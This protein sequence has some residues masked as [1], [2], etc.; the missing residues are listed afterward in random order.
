MLNKNPFFIIM[1]LLPAFTAS[2]GQQFF[3]HGSVSE[4]STGTPL[5]YA[6]IRV[7]NSS[8]GTSSNKNGRY[9]LKLSKGKYKIFAS[10]IGYSSDTLEIN[11]QN[12]LSD[13][14]FKLRQTNITLPEIVV[15]PGENPALR[16][17]KAAIARKEEKD[18]ILNSYEFDAYTKAIIKT[19]K[20]IGSNGRGI[21]MNIGSDTSALK[22][23]GIIENESKG[24][25][26]KPNLYKEEITARRQ[27][28]N[29]P[30]S[31]NILT[32]GRIMKDFSGDYVNLLGRDIPGPL[33][34]N[35]LDYYFFHIDMMTSINNKPVYVIYMT[36]N[37]TNDPGFYGDIY[38]EDSTY[39]LIKVD[40]HINRAANI[41]GILDSVNIYQQFAAYSNSI[42]MPVDYRLFVKA[43]VLGLAKF[44]LELNTILYDYKIKTP[45]SK[46][47]FNKAVIT[48]LPGADKKDSTYWNEA[49][50]VPSTP[51]EKKAYKRIDSLSSIKPTFWER[52]SL[53]ST[54]INLT[55]NFSV[56][57]PL[58]MYHFNRVE[59]NSLD[60]GFF[61]SDAA[62]HRLNSSLQFDYGFS[63][64][65]FKT[66]F[67]ISY[68]L[69]DYRTY[70]LSFNA[71]NRLDVLF[72]ESENYNDFFSSLLALISKDDFR[73]YY[74]SKGFK[75]EAAGDVSPVIRLRAG[76]MNTT[77]KSA[78]RNTEFSF[79]AKDKQ[80]NPNPAI[81]D[82][83]INAVNAGFK[84]D[85]RDYIENGISR[86]RISENKSYITFNGNVT[87][88]DKSLL[89]SSLYY[90]TYELSSQGVLNTFT[91]Q[92]LDFKIFGMYTDGKLPYQNLYSLPG[93]IDL[94]AG[95][96]TF[97]TLN[98]NEVLGDRVVEV[99]LEH[100]FGDE[101]F[102][103][104]RIPYLQDAELQLT[105]FI[106]AAYS[107]I[108]KGSKSILPEEQPGTTY[109]IKTLRHPFYEAGFELGHVLFPFKL[110]FAWRLNY[111]GE[112]NFRIGLN[113]FFLW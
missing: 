29:F 103:A 31:I 56:S 55:D 74:Y 64:K 52:F 80:Y 7:L 47:F 89:K 71:F 14:N 20:A 100:E 6:N 18:K 30:P 70:K 87:L 10:Y 13:V 40:L 106:N 91:S 33:A 60:Y 63:D 79:F 42:Y 75:F 102:R 66:D 21:S 68:L 22:I 37:N 97:R 107:D 61:L 84:L 39:E 86:M 90:T 46:S 113:V 109:Q 105:G 2:F 88:S 16:I 57:A 98:V 34:P 94:T 112:N 3:V 96:F 8:L 15:H 23:T 53:L 17:I 81:Y 73:N 44:G 25:Y 110:D 26:K 65:R 43:N 95:N 108:G 76:I 51:E 35:A 101:L 111:R 24:F 38:I 36:P 59:G 4:K 83:K 54:R 99:F 72:G 19:Q 27:T 69:G 78:F 48:V 12:D 28:A 93:N 58:A 77:Y 104:L 92:Q 9:K 5:I 67:N 1:I 32:G 45:I 49:V 62:D 41:G 85:F 50:T 11:L 82:T